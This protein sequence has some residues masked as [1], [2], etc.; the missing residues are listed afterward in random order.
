MT[1]RIP[2]LSPPYE[3]E[4]ETQLGSM[5]PAGVPPILLF[6]TMA[7]NLEMTQAMSTWGGYELSNRLSLSL[8]ERE[9]VIDRVCALCSCEYEW[10]V[11]VAFFAEAA[12]FTPEQITSLTHGDA[13]DACWDAVRDRLLVEAVDAMH[14]NGDVSV[15]LWDQLAGEFSHAELLDLTMLCGWY[16]AIS[17]T[18][19]VAGVPLED[20]APRFADVA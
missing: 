2:A 15:E 10:G 19:N 1:H 8:R 14:A 18:A 9:I 7:T 20:G 16:H 5:M 17:Y 3:P 12:G 11:H 6:R 13:A 4:T